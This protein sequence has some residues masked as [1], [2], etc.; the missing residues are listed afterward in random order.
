MTKSG[1]EHLRKPQWLHK[2]IFFKERREVENLLGEIGIHTV[3]QEAMCPNISEC[4]HKKQ[5]T[6]MILGNVCTRACTFC[7]VDRGHPSEL[8]LAEPQKVA[9]AVREMG[10]RHVVI[11]SVTRDDLKDG[12]A[13]QFCACVEAIKR[14]DPSVSVELLIPDLRN[15]EEALQMVA[16]SKAEVIGHNIETV[17]RLYEVRKGSS[18]RRS[19]EV[20]QTLK[21]LNPTCK[22]KSAL[23]LGFGEREEE[24][25]ESLQDLLDVGCRLLSI[26]QYLRPS[27]EHTPV[28]EFVKPEVFERYGKMALEMG[29][30]YVKS[31]PY[32]RSSYMAH[33]YLEKNNA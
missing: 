12:G 18:Y 2:K 19:L 31:S 25:R 30:E 11:T 22:T 23:M 29:F 4:F 17:P 6:F 1:S 33:E 28:V 21:E 20:L 15:V 5:A 13:A 14:D 9:R 16:N 8:D 26:G 7:S 32:T 3:C 24:V 10:L 27:L